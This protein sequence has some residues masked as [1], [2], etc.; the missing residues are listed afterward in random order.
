MREILEDY[1]NIAYIKEN[2]NIENWQIEEERS[3]EI[4]VLLDNDN[5]RL[6]LI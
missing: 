5:K 1:E 4:T 2:Y 3:R 6:H